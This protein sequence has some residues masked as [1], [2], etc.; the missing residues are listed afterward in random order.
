[1]IICFSVPLLHVHGKMADGSWENGGLTLG[2]FSVL[3]F[4]FPSVD[5][6]RGLALVCVGLPWVCWGQLL[7]YVCFEFWLVVLGR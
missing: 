3:L 2:V 5:C 1:M 7:A 6:W 4:I